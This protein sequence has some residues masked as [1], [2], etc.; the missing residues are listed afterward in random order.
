[1]SVAAIRAALE[2]A[3]DE[4]TPAI[5]TAWENAPFTPVEDEPYQA[6]SLQ[7]GEPDNSE[8]GPQHLE[9]GI[10]AVTLCYPLG[11]GPA[12]A[13][14]RAE[15]LRQTFARGSSFTTSGVTTTVQKTPEVAPALTEA[16][17]YVV[18]VRIRFQAPV[19]L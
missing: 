4:I 16:D 18:A 17:R 1:M 19:N 6:V 7:L 10:F 9:R 3:L 8:I 11:E 14:A 13:E 15:L 2:S 12:A 5:A